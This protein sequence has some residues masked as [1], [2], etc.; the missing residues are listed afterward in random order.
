MNK[1]TSS[2][3]H[4]HNEKEY[5]PPGDPENWAVSFLVQRLSCSVLLVF[6]IKIPQ[7]TP[8]KGC[9]HFNTAGLLVTS[10]CNLGSVTA[11]S[12][13]CTSSGEIFLYVLE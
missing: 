5:V 13:R 8:V 1:A 7:V 12:G 4:S 6:S 3:S 9:D 2:E 11:S 10:T